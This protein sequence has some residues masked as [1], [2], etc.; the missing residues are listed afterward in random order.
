M[1]SPEYEKWFL[2]AGESFRR[3]VSRIED[4]TLKPRQVEGRIALD[5]LWI[6]RIRREENR[7]PDEL[8]G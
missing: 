6:A 5:A 4:L 3:G 2:I 7:M 1:E 8:A